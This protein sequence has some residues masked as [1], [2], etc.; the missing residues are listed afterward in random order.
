MNMGPIKQ[1]QQGVVLV[2]SLI[3]LLVMTLIGITGMNTT[4]LEE[5]MAGNFRDKGIAFQAAESALKTA[6]LILSPTGE[7]T[8]CLKTTLLTGAAVANCTISPAGLHTS[9]PAWEDLDWSAAAA[10]IATDAILSGNYIIV[11]LA[12]INESDGSLETGT[13]SEYTYYRITSQA[14]GGTNTSIAMLQT[15]YKR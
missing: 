5:K 11:E 14:K 1:K 7:T 9:A 12:T 6:E 3:M 4:I 13:A 8:A 15:I 2:I 10:D